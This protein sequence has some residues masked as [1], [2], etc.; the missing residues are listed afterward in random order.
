MRWLLAALLL[1][2]APAAAQAPSAAPQAQAQ[3]PRPAAPNP[4][5]AE[6]D[7][8]LD[9]LARAPDA[10]HA[11]I[12]ETRIRSLWAQGASPAVTLLMRRGLRNLAGNAP[13]EAVEDFDAALALQPSL[14]D[15]FIL[16]AQALASL[17][18]ARAAA[19]DIQRALALEPRHFGA[20]VALAQILSEAGDHDGALRAFEAALALNP[21][22]QDGQRQ[23]DEYRRR[24][25]GEAM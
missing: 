2:A 21:R 14:P 11:T 12:I 4:R 16:R 7:R 23:R 1:A 15:A 8:L 3:A 19:A 18:D 6:L 17:G 10:E 25:E 22:M 13:D 24:A 20:L 5:R 9:E